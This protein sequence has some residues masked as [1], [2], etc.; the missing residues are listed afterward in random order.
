MTPIFQMIYEE[1]GELTSLHLEKLSKTAEESVLK[2][3][4]L[5]KSLANNKWVLDFHFTCQV[6]QNIVLMLFYKI[7]PD[8][9]LKLWGNNAECTPDRMI[10]L[11]SGQV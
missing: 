11:H 10:S 7:P 1:S 2:E 5:D 9:S 3:L 4:G 8:Q 6:D